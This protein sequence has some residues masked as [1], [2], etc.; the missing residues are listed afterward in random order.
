MKLDECKSNLIQLIK[1]TDPNLFEQ[2]IIPL[3]QKYGVQAVRRILPI[4]RYSTNLHDERLKAVL[5]FIIDEPTVKSHE[6]GLLDTYKDLSATFFLE[7]LAQS[8]LKKEYVPVLKLLLSEGCIDRERFRNFLLCEGV[9]NS[10]FNWF[11]WSF[12][13]PNR[14][15]A[16][17]LNLI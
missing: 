15:L 6:E 9:Y 14:D 1:K 13:K 3:I 11:F 12:R 5:D 8:G 10:P 2:L 7:N 16:Q 17:K 4:M